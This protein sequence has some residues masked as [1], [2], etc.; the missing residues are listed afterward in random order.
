MCLRWHLT[1]ELGR[2]IFLFPAVQEHGRASHC[3]IPVLG[4][5][6]SP[7]SPCI[8]HLVLSADS[9]FD[10]Y[11]PQELPSL[12][13]G[14]PSLL[15]SRFLP[16]LSK[17]MTFE[18]HVKDF[19][20][21]PAW[22]A[23]P[24]GLFQLILTLL[25]LCL[26]AVTCLVPLPCSLPVS[27]V[28]GPDPQPDFMKQMSQFCVHFT[29]LYCWGKC[30]CRYLGKSREMFFKTWPNTSPWA[31]SWLKSVAMRLKWC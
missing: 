18:G 17:S 19:F 23:W 25:E 10:G 6:P 21:S 26:D 28:P 20:H 7:S 16:S 31:C 1:A 13:D 4:L 12:L 8:P 2:T 11:G 3:P 5:C 14:P 27:P 30:I 29:G 15:L 24:V 22:P 9:S